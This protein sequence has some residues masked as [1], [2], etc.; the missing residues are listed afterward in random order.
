MFKKLVSFSFM[1]SAMLLLT[2]GAFAAENIYSSEN[3]QQQVQ[4]ENREVLAGLEPSSTA[5]S[6]TYVVTA[7]GVRLRSTHSLSGTVLGLLYNGDLVNAQTGGTDVTADGY[8]W[9]NV[10]SYNHGVWGWIVV[11]YIEEAG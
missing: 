4:A 9:K 11:D 10:Y 6:S 3:T 2:Q 1:I 7:D 5:R 8:V